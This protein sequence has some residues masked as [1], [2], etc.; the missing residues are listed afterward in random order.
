MLRGFNMEVNA[1]S[2]KRINDV[3][4]EVAARTASDVNELSEA[5]EKVAS[6]ASASGMEI[7]ST[8]SMLAQ[9]IE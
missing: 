4:S 5:T 8:V 7:E 2:A 6:L 9:M 3:Y 1:T